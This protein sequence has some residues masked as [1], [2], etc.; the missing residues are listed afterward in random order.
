MAANWL[1]SCKVES[2]FTHTK[3]STH[4]NFTITQDL[5][6]MQKYIHNKM[7]YLLKANWKHIR[8]NTF[9]FLLLLAK[10]QMKELRKSYFSEDHRKM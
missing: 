2:G 3:Y 8:G 5:R 7:I 6:V 9:K 1:A 10:N 4:T